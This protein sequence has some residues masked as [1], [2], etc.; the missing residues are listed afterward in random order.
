MPPVPHWISPLQD[1]RR[2]KLTLLCLT[3]W[4][5]VCYYNFYIQNICHIYS[6]LNI[7]GCE[8]QLLE[9]SHERGKG[10]DMNPLIFGLLFYSLR[11]TTKEKLPL[12][13]SRYQNQ[14]CPMRRHII[15]LRQH[16]FHINKHMIIC[17]FAVIPSKSQ[18]HARTRYC[19]HTNTNQGS[20]G[21][22]YHHQFLIP[23]GH[24]CIWI[25]S[26]HLYICFFVTNIYIK[27]SRVYNG[28]YPHSFPSRYL[29]RIHMILHVTCLLKYETS[30]F[31]RQ[32]SVSK[33]RHQGAT[34]QLYCIHPIRC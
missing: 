23:C 18:F 11:E 24:L 32:W 17:I 30:K 3:S 15:S 31:I 6:L 1:A 26:R 10:D 12:N 21:H 22:R 16:K 34:M 33:N 5:Y 25:K 20:R 13:C 29:I 14:Q 27:A 28:T 9:P 7:N 2:S 19:H 4:L 8:L